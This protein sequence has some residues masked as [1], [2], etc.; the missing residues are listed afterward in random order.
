MN[1]V[2]KPRPVNDRC[3]T[4]SKRPPW[5]VLPSVSMSGPESPSEMGKDPSA[6]P[7]IGVSTGTAEEPVRFAALQSRNFRLLWFGMLISNAGT[8]MESTATG[9]LMTDLEPERAA[10]WLGISAAAFAIPMLVLPP[11]GGAMADRFSRISVLWV[12]QSLYMALSLALA[13]VTLTDVVAVWM[14][15]VFSFG[16]GVVLAFDAPARHALLPDIVNRMQLTSAVSLNSVAFTGA[17]LI[18]PAIAGVLIPFIGVGGVMAVNVVSCLA[19]LIALA[20][21]RNIPV[22]IPGRHD[23]ESVVKSIAR[24]VRHILGSPLLSGLIVV[25]AI[26]GLLVRSYSPMLAVFA[27]DEFHVGSGA[28]GAMVSAGGLGTL[29]GAF[30]FA[31]RRNV[32]HKGRVVLAAVIAQS[33]LLIIFAVSPWY[34]L[35]LPLLAFAGLTNALAGASIATL[36][37]LSVPPDLRGRIMSLYLLTVIGV[38][39]VGSFALGVAAVP[40]GVRAAV[41]AAALISIVAIGAVFA[42]NRPLREAN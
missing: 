35:S 28:Y 13:I 26:G 39:S 2:V 7:P 20:L 9:W 14:L 25:S 33:G 24:G 27:R 16:I 17:S 1:R 15:I 30:G 4:S 12:V 29:I 11:F 36:I 21:L 41:G 22:R 5:I 6:E 31:G 32:E 37:Q 10:F 3:R 18:G 23:A 42:R 38:P 8:W 34:A 40:F 19:T